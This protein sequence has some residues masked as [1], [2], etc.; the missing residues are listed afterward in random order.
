M[1]ADRWIDRV[2]SQRNHLPEIDELR[3]VED[4]LRSLIKA[5]Q[6]AERELMPVQTAY[7]DA[8]R[9]SERLRKRESE[10]AKALSSSTAAARDLSAIHGELDHL[11][12]LLAANEDRELDFLLAVE[13]LHDVVTALKARAQPC[14]ERRRSSRTRLPRCKRPSTRSSFRFANSAR[15]RRRCY[16]ENCWRATTRRSCEWEP[17]EPPK[18]TRDDATVVESRSPHSISIVG[19]R[20][21]RTLHGVP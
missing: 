12:E 16:L 9:E 1:Q 17:R 20:I 21:T 14:V 7:D 19:N 5:I 6:E 2:T 8:S 3:S 18:W 13:P 10:L 15:K 4:E 11:R